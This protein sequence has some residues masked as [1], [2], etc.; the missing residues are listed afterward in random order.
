MVLRLARTSG[1]FRLLILVV[2]VAAAVGLIALSRPSSDSDD[3]AK[4]AAAQRAQ[5]QSLHSVQ[6]RIR[7]AERRD[8]VLRRERARLREDQRAH[9]ARVPADV[10]RWPVGS[11]AEQT[12]VVGSLERAIT[13][14]A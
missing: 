7:A 2:A 14:E 12:A 11:R 10:A 5:L 9:F 6:A 8:P 4:A 1:P 3:A 13:R